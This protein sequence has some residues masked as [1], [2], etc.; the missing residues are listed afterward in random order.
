MTT[1]PAPITNPV[2]D[3]Q[4]LPTLPWTLFFNQNFEGDAGNAWEPNIVNL[5]GS[6]S[7]VSGRFYRI[8]QYLVYF[9]ITISPSGP[10]SSTAGTTYVDNFPLLFNADGVN[11]VVSGSSGGSLGMNR[12]SDN[13]ILFPPWTNVS[14]PLVVLGILEAT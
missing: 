2:I 6:T 14:L 1:N 8:S 5:T 4:G 13:R 7:A 12:Q 10:T 3:E 9:T 11:A